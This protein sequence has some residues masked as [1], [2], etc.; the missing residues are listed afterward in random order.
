MYLNLRKGSMEKKDFCV[1]D[2]VIVANSGGQFAILLEEWPKGKL[3]ISGDHTT[4]LFSDGW[5]V[6]WPEHP[7]QYT[8]MEREFLIAL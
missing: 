2:L 5:I 1:G 8:V 4:N 3:Y 6:W 7:H